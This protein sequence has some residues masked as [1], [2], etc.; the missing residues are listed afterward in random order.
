MNKRT[1]FRSTFY[2]TSEQSPKLAKSAAKTS[3]EFASGTVSTQFDSYTKRTRFEKLKT[4]FS[5]K[6]F[7][8]F[9]LIAGSIRINMATLPAFYFLF[10]YRNNF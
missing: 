9:C 4:K 8:H 7:K 5:S 10:I 3:L 2:I 1:G 6:T